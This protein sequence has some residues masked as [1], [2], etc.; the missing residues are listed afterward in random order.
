MQRRVGSGTLW[1]A[2]RVSA[3][4]GATVAL[5]VFDL[6]LTD[7]PRDLIGKAT[8]GRVAGEG[9]PPGGGAA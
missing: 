3:S 4:S 7:T 5:T 9:F 6:R 8:A 2:V 1:L